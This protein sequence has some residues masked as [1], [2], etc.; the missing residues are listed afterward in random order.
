MCFNISDNVTLF[1]FAFTTKIKLSL[2]LKSYKK[3]GNKTLQNYETV[4]HT[5]Y[6]ALMLCTRTRTPS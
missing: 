1:F 3:R 5:V 6:V 4:E 2:C